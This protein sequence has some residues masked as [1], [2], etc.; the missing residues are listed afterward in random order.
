MLFGIASYH[1]RYV[2]VGDGL[3]EQRLAHGKLHVQFTAPAHKK[4]GSSTL[5]RAQAGRLGPARPFSAWL[6]W[7]SARLWLPKWSFRVHE[8]NVF[9]K[10]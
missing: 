3:A 4:N 5:L 9:Q 1:K 8:T 10:K 6:D 7:G 2:S